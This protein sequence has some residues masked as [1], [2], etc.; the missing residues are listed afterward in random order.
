MNILFICEGFNTSSIVAQ[1][2]KHVAEI[3]R[4]MRKRGIN[5]QIIS[6][7]KNRDDETINGVPVKRV[8]KRRFL[9][10]V[11]SLS[12]KIS[13]EDVD[14]VNWHASDLWSSSYF[15]HLKKEMKTNFIWTIHSRVITPED[16]R[17]LRFL[18]YLE[19]YKFWNNFLNASIPHFLIRKWI[20]VPFLVHVLALSR[21]IAEN[22]LCLGFNPG[23]VTH[24]PSGVDIN[25]FQ[26]SRNK[27]EGSTILYFGPLSRFRGVDTLLSAFKLLRKNLPKARLILLARGAEEKDRF[28]KRKS[29]WANIEINTEILGQVELVN[30]LN[31]ASVVVLPF[32]FWPQVE[33]PLTVLEAMAMGKAVVTT[34]IGA[35]QEIVKHKQN[36]LVVPPGNSVKLA[37]AVETL[38]RNQSMCLNLGSNARARVERCYDWNIIVDKTVKILS[39]HSS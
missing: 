22:A 1:P 14:V 5:V 33:C 38:L 36:G 8:E 16:L 23:M 37:I 32:R 6:D 18:D 7:G 28:F 15:W 26:P 20:S 4:R 19:L 12:R 27:T 13:E 9:M 2:W 17:N 24:I 10:D 25:L 11:K 29:K 34:S 35:I 39:S 31:R 21:R 30:Y 3:S